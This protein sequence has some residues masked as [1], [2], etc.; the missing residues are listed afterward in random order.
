MS[1]TDSGA[2]VVE[3]TLS[4]LAAQIREESSQRPASIAPLDPALIEYCRVYCAHCKEWM[5][6]GA[7]FP[8]R[9]LSTCPRCSWINIFNGTIQPIGAVLR[10]GPAPEPAPCS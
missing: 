4:L 8:V 2:S 7:R 6:E 3:N 5:I 9:A 1:K 10:I